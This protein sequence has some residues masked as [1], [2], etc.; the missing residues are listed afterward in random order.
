MLRLPKKQATHEELFLNRYPELLSW[1]MRVSG[2]DRDRAEDLVQ[3]AYIQWMLVKP[4]VQILNLDGYLYGMLRNIHSAEKRRAV[5]ANQTSLTAV[6]YD[7]ALLSLHRA[8]DE[9]HLAYMQDQLRRV[10]EYACIR[11]ETSKGGSLFLLRFFHGYYPSEAARLAGVK[12]VTVDSWLRLARAEA[13]LYLEN[14]E[15]L[16]FVNLPPGTRQSSVVPKNEWEFLDDATAQIFSSCQSECLTDKE[17]RRL[18]VE[19]APVRLDCTTLAHIC[20]CERCLVKAA[21]ILN[22]PTGDDRCPP[23]CLR[24]DP[25]KGE[26]SQSRRMHGTQE[27]RMRMEDVTEHRPRELQIAVNGFIV[28]TQKVISERIEHSLKVSL[29]EQIGFVEV[30]SEQ[31][32]RL[33]SLY[34]EPPPEGS[35]EHSASVELSD[36]RVLEVALTFHE[37]WPTLELIYSDPHFAEVLSDP[38]SLS[39]EDTDWV[40]TPVV[41]KKETFQ[42]SSLISRLKT[43][44]LDRPFWLRPG[45]ASAVCL[46]VVL[47][48]AGLYFL[49]TRSTPP[50]ASDVLQRAQN[51][52]HVLV[53]PGDVIH[54][55]ISFEMHKAGA[56]VTRQ[57]IEI[58]QGGH[59]NTARRLYD[60]T[61]GLVAG[62][63]QNASSES[64]NVFYHHGSKLKVSSPSLAQGDAVPA[65]HLWLLD[66]SATT[67]AALVR[68][69]ESVAIETNEHRY[70]LIY[71]KPPLTLSERPP[72]S[73]SDL[74]NLTE[75]KLT[76]DQS[77]MRAVSQSLIFAQGSE[78]T[79]FAFKEL[80]FERLPQA[81]VSQRIFQPDPELLVPIEQPIISKREVAVAVKPPESV[82]IHA[83]TA[84][85]LAALEVN[86]LYL[87]DKINA[88]SGEQI[89]VRRLP[90]REL[91]V[92]AIVDSDKRKKEILSVL[93]SVAGNPLVRMDV[94]TFE[95]ALRRQTSSSRAPGSVETVVI[96]SDRIP[97]EDELRRYLQSARVKSSPAEIDTEIQRFS[98][99]M[100]DLSREGLLHAFALKQIVERFSASDLGAMNEESRRKWHEMI[101]AHASGFRQSS[102]TLRHELGPIFPSLEGIQST[103][104]Q[105]EIRDDAALIEAVKNLMNCAL[106]T[107]EAISRAFSVSPDTKPAMNSPNNAIF[108]RTLS[109]AEALAAAI[110]RI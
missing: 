65:D 48:L 87:L 62:A 84:A 79:E 98:G 46:A 80:G 36:D 22:L 53:G 30:L 11:K 58:W 15:A 97:V 13:K 95:E 26:K 92:E 99:R 88:N 74:P 50:I 59:G 23:D 24:R 49:R 12:R 33:L 35:L 4:D 1:S 81:S 2:N 77:T 38:E 39:S 68:G 61:G 82:T 18:Y 52:E 103:D 102:N 28:G 21:K 69:M 96:N 108:W 71:R 104:A 83:P 55:N 109:R 64:Q 70:T 7:S 43:A 34:V 86:V 51:V 54:R 27:F 110:E 78:L 16:K 72:L 91:L 67:F 105:V 44:R 100:I 17:L 73:Q 47:V 57:R 63:W 56:R 89:D 20:S 19:S 10:C 101:R 31:G 6:E 3:D 42:F 93:A 8:N 75:A 29:L 106:A 94:V 14:P 37:Q 45:P 76:I 32:I 41:P 66:P 9:G 40:A 85:E 90:G 107:D 25:E 60:E 5:R